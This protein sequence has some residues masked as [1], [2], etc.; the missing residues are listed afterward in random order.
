MPMDT[1]SHELED[2]SRKR[3]KQNMMNKGENINEKN[4]EE[5]TTEMWHIHK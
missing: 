5:I 2:W 1:T 4:K 3:R